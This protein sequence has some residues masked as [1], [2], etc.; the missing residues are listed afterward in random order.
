MTKRPR[1]KKAIS[2][3]AAAPAAAR[4]RAPA[5]KIVAQRHPGARRAGNGGQ[6]ARHRRVA[7]QGED[8]RQVSRP[9]LPRARDGR[10]R[11]GSAREEARH[12]RRATAS[13]RSTS[14]FPARKRRSPSSRARRRTRRDVF[15]AT[16]PDRE[17]EAIA[18]HV[19]E[20]DQ[21]EGDAGARSRVL[22]HEITKDA[23][24]RAIANAGVIDEQEGRGAAGASRAR[25][26]R[27]LQGEPGALEDGEEGTL[28]GP[29]ADGRAAA[30]R[31]ARARDSRVQAG[32]VLDRSR[33]CSRRR[34]S[35]SPRK[36]HQI[37]GKKPEISNEREAMRHS[38][39]AVK[40]RETFQVTE[41]KR[42]ERRKNPQAPFTTS[43]L[44]Q[45]AAKKLSFGSQAHDARRAGSLR[46]HR[47]RR[48]GRGGSHHLHAY[49]LH[50]RRRESRRSRR[51][52]ICA[53]CSARSSSRRAPQLYGDVEG[54]RTRRTRTKPCVPRIRRAG[55]TH[56]KKYLKPDQFKLYQLIW[57]RFMASQMAPAVFDTTTVDF[58]IDGNEGS[59]TSA[60]RALP[61]PRRRAA[62]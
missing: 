9:R 60:R 54:R 5:K 39:N 28:R 25:S 58:D 36:L 43:T 7:R 56:I 34:G 20:T 14:R 61:V 18:W 38:S 19:A 57:Q 8:H 27:R 30:D 11:P 49:R 21:A 2:A 16:D 31:R 29:R 55:R 12:R 6:V 37:D 10:P 46:R 51:A 44:Q 22:F 17:G 40:S 24:Q 26:A 23:V 1:A 59:R 62:S 53:R 13:S 4:K 15:I 47:A 50:A 48:R 41:V 3:A 32:R 45:E 52:T 35:S 42:R 33:R